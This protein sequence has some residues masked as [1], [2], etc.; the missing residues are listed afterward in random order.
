MKTEG[1]V[2]DRAK[3][4]AR[5]ALLA[6]LVCMG[7]ISL[8][9]PFAHERIAARWFSLPNFYYL[10][11]VPIVTALAAFL[12]WRWIETRR[13]ALPFLAAIALFLLGY[14]GLVISNYPFLV[15]PT[16]TVWDTAAV[17]ASQIFMLIG[18]LVLLP[19]IIGYFIVISG[20][21]A[22]RCARAKAITDARINQR[23]LRADAAR[24]SR[25]ASKAIGPGSAGR[26]RA[27]IRA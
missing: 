26:M 20:S 7:I 22:A 12:C 23:R 18:T 15:P 6:V 25:H 17:P 1:A 16:L 3:Q 21:S 24:P 4:Q 27:A 13:D 14:L 2:A 9:T 10:A 11:P 19:M 5:L 8:W